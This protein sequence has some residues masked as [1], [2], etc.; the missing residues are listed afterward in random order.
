[1][2]KVWP[3]KSSVSQVTAWQQV[4]SFLTQDHSTT[5]LDNEWF[6][7]IGERTSRIEAF[8]WAK[9]SGS[10]NFLQLRS[11]SPNGLQNNCLLTNFQSRTVFWPLK[12]PDG[13]FVLILN[14]KLLIGSRKNTKAHFSKLS[15]WMRV[16]TLLSRI[17]KTLS[18]EEVP[19]SLKTLMKSLIQ[20]SIHCLKRTSLT[21][22]DK[23]TL[24]WQ[25]TLSITTKV[26][27]FTLQ[28]NFRIPSILPKLWVRLWS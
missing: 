10:K 3:I 12:P 15:T 18:R 8:Q 14:S 11:K 16:Q 20:P 24:S 27:N 17:F 4:P 7:K 6:I 22:R 2:N 26:S 9:N 21:E 1:M 13:H 19:V 28:P 23:S 5:T 25:I